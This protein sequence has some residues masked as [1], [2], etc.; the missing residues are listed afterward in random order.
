[1]ADSIFTVI[2]PTSCSLCHNELAEAGTLDIC[3]DC[4]AALEPWSGPACSH[5]GL[6]LASERTLD[7]TVSLCSQCRL[8]EFDFDRARSYGLYAGKLRAAILQ[9][10]FRR[11]ERLGKKL[12]ALMAL[13]WDS[14]VEDRDA[15][16]MVLVPVP[17]HHSRQRE[18][19]FNQAELLAHGLSRTL[20]RRLDKTRRRAIPRAEIRCLLR[21]RATVSQTGL[22][23]PQRR[24][25]VR[26]VF[27]VSR[28]ERIRDREVI[29]VDDVMT[30]GATLSACAGA[31]KKAGA[32][33]V[34]GLTLARA[35]PQFP[36]LD[37]AEDVQALDDSGRDWT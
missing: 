21:T 15:S 7:A 24:E 8:E 37:V 33:R 35:T 28:P 25:N 4:W 29:V 26:G 2:F 6:P 10:K 20:A 11:R 30:T 16:P 5:C 23:V 34:M 13:S 36:D 27:A 18:R 31:L 22:T 32:Q 12:G 1:M 17:L 14:L 19:G 3:R 9:L